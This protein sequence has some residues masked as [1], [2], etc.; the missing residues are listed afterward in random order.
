MF[1]KVL[2]GTSAVALALAF[3]AAQAVPVDYVWNGNQAIPDNDAN[4][5]SVSINVAE[6]GTILDLNVD[7]VIEHTWQGDLIIELEQV[8]GPTVALIWRAGDSSNP[9]GFGFSADNYGTLANPFVFDD[10]AGLFYDSAQPNGIGAV[11]DPGIADVG[12]SWI[13]YGEQPGDTHTLAAFD[14]LDLNGEWLLHVSDNANNDTGS[15]L[16]FSLHFDIDAGGAVPEPGTLVL[17][18]LGFVALAGSR[19]RSRKNF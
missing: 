13:P 4:G 5:T 8:G 3:S 7:I 18:G 17:L 11:G 2:K 16:Q 14:G 19:R 15:I 12:G 6:T 10:E 9:N 1:G